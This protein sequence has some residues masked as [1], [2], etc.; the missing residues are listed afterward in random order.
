M[1]RGILIL[2]ADES[3]RIIERS[4]AQSGRDDAVNDSDDK[5]GYFE[6]ERVRVSQ[7]DGGDVASM[8]FPSNFVVGLD[9]EFLESSKISQARLEDGIN[10]TSRR[11]MSKGV[12]GVLNRLPPRW[13][14]GRT[15]IRL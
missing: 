15:T 1:V 8:R 7:I 3:V 6:D 4:L 10:L 12:R 9:V 11:D 2:H 5:E 13:L 14:I